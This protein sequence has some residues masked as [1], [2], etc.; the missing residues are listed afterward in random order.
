MIRKEAVK[1]ITKSVGKNP[2]ISANGFM[3]RDLFEVNDKESNFY[4]I[5]SMGLASSIGLGIALKNV[6]KRVFVFDGDGNI[7]MNLGSLVTIG[8]L[9]P[10]N[11]IHIVFDNNSHESTGGQ[12][13]NSSK[14]KLEKLAKNFNYK[15][16]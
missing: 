16:L 5:G 14:I 1:I 10:K 7:L 2:I 3:S 8:S 11:L 15:F 12:P 6:K 4:M 9:K 13:T